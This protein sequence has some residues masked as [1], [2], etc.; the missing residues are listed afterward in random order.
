MRIGNSL[1]QLLVSII[2]H[3]NIFDKYIYNYDNC[4]N[5]IFFKIS[6]T[7]FLCVCQ[8]FWKSLFILKITIEGL[9]CSM[10]N[11][12]KNHLLKGG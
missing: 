1:G 4:Y 12:S 11:S 5:E 10:E 3:K 7:N 9:E 8:N 2:N 6:L